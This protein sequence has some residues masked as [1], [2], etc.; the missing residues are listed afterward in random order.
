MVKWAESFQ[1]SGT[2]VADDIPTKFRKPTLETH[3][4]PRSGCSIIISTEEMCLVLSKSGL[5]LFW[6]CLVVALVCYL[7]PEVEEGLISTENYAGRVA[8]NQEFGIVDKYIINSSG[9]G[10]F[11]L[12]NS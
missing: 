5:E 9:W 4:Y 11:S 10:E 7:L 1:H 12:E 6:C 3:I 8:Q 2:L